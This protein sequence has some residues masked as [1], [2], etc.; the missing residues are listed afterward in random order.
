MRKWIPLAAICL[1][2]FM[3][4]VDVSIVNVALPK[5]SVDLHS[6]FTSL[7]WVVDIYA[8]TLAALLMALGSLG[9][10]L[11]HRRLYLGGLVLFA[12]ASL[13]CA[14]APDAATLI[15]SRAAQGIGGAAMMTSTTALLNGA[16]QGR[17]RGTAFAVWGAVNGAAAAVGPVLGGLLTDQFGWRAIFMVNVPVAVLALAMTLGYLKGGSGVTRGRIDLAGALSFTVFAGSLVYGLIESGDKGWGSVQ[18]LGPLA[19]GVLALVVFAVAELRAGH[20]LLD[21]A[22]LRNRTFL[23][24][25]VGGLLLNAAAFAQLTYVSIWL[26][27][28]LDLTP[29]NAGLAVCPLALASFAVSLATGK[30]VHRLAP[31]LPIGVGLLLI[32]GG[33]LLLG[34]VSAGSNWT[35]LLPGLLVSG[36]GVGLATP[37]LMST[38]LAS[39]P[40][41][42]A[43]MASGAV[44]TGRQLGYALGIA[45]LGT[46]FQDRVR[47]FTGHAAGRPD[48][49][50]AFAAGLDRVFLVAGCAGL[51]AGVLVLALVRRPAPV[52]G[53]WAPGQAAAAPAEAAPAVAAAT[54]AKA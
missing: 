11:G 40:R 33:T 53:A 23:G 10:R 26:Q 48:L 15:A 13:T 46:V 7:Q 32:G 25:T 19:L 31:Q 16:Y 22:L 18:V 27:Q 41:E 51:V 17:D 29:L 12:V 21:L 14:L 44:N 5:M 9:D 2:A 45:L 39:V 36:V 54:A 4:L 50:A 20:P 47:Q 3:L 37:Q 52:P 34:L 28:A 6:S 35:A 38:A 1:G 30:A 8:L 49:H 43:G 24:L 42:R